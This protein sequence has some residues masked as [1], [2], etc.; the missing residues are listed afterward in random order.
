MFKDFFVKKML[1]VKGVSNEQAEMVIA[2]MNKN[3]DLFKQI[4]VEIEARVKNGENQE[5]AAMAVMLA[6]QAELQSLAK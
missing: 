2:L 3:P 5:Q 6:H 4:A 1:Q